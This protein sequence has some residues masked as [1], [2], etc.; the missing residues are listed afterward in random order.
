LAR[1]AALNPAMVVAGHKKP[2]ATHSP[3]MI[4]SIQETKRYPQGVDRAQKSATS[5]EELFDRM[6]ELYR[7]G[8]PIS[9]G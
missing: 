9:R 1:L 5:D 7:I 4:R 2:G 3:S 6:T 8:R